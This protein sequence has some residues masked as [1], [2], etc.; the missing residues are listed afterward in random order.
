MLNGPNQFHMQSI[1]GTGDRAEAAAEA[2]IGIDYRTIVIH[3]YC[4]HLAPFHTGFAGL[5]F[6]RINSC[7][8]P[9][10]VPQIIAIENLGS[11][12]DT[13]PGRAHAELFRFSFSAGGGDQ[14]GGFTFFQKGIAFFQ[15]Y[16]FAYFSVDDIFYRF[17]G[18]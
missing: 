18:Q 17:L 8:K 13:F 5:A 7:I 12:D 14:S 4:A 3:G 9:A 16:L 6:V 1:G 10:S 11:Q 15:G 2:L